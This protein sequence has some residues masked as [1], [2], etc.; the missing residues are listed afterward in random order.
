M[1]SAF[2][3]VDL[4]DNEDIDEDDEEED[5]DEDD[6]NSNFNKEDTQQVVIENEFVAQK[7][8]AINCLQ[9]IIKYSNPQFIDFH[10]QC[11]EELKTLTSFLHSNIKKE[12]FLAF[13]NLIAY[14]HDFF[15]ANIVKIN[16][17]QKGAMLKSI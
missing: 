8:A 17:A 2:D 3:E 14:F 15:M 1:F 5:D 16:D 11:V 13:A 9:E 12:S 7:L 6:E 4:Q 10:D